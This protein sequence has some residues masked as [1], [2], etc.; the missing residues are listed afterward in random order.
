MLERKDPYP[1]L[2]LMQVAIKVAKGDAS[3]HNYLTANARYP[4]VL[5]Q[6]MKVFIYLL[7]TLRTVSSTIQMTDL[8]SKML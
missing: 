8:N 2:D 3:L 5:V 7:M 1:G 6:L 4:P